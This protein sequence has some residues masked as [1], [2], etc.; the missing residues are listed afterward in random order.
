MEFAERKLWRQVWL[1]ALAAALASPCPAQTTSGRIRGTVQDHSGAV[2]PSVKITTTNTETG[3]QRSTTSN[4][5][6]QYMVY[7][8]PPGIYQLTAGVTGF[9]TERVDGIR[10][11]VADTVL[12]NITLQIGQIEQQVTVSAEATPTLTQTASVESTIV[13]EQIDSLPLNGRDFNQ[14]VLLAAGAVDTNNGGNHDFGGVAVNGNRSFSNDYLLDGTP[15]NDV[16]QGKSAAPVSVDLIRDFKVTSGVAPAEYG[17]AGTQISV[18]TRGGTNQVHGSVFEYYRGNALE[19]RNPFNTGAQQPFRRNQFGGSV[20]GPVRLP[21]YNGVNRTFFYFN[22]EGNR[23]S[24]NVTRVA[25]VPPDDFW[26]GDFSSLLARGIQ[27]RDPLAAGRPVIPNNRLDQ[28][29]GGAFI[30]KTAQA[31][32]PFWGSPTSSGLANNLV[33]YSQEVSNA[34]QFTLRGDQVLPRNQVLALR[35]T[36]SAQGGFTPSILANNTGLSNPVDTNNVSA[37]WTATISARTVSELR[38]GYASFLSI[39]T[40]DDGGLPTVESLKL[41]GFEPGNPGIPPMVRINF[42]GN[43]AFTQLNYGSSESYGM[44]ALTKDSKIYN[45]SEAIS[46]S[47][48][49]HNIKAGFEVRRLPMNSLQQTN[50]RGQLTFRSATSGA[51]TGY[52]FAD[53]LMGL[54]ASTQEV[55]VKQN[56]LFK[57]TETAAYIQDDW[58]V[59]SRLT[60]TLG[61]RHE[62]F[63]NPYEQRNRLAMFDYINGAMVVASDDGKLP[64]DQFLPSVVAKLT[65]AQGNWKFPLIGDKQAG[66]NPRRLVDTQWRHLGPRFGFVNQLDRQGRMVIKG[67]Y[68]IF[69]TRYPIQYLLQTV[70]VNPPFAGLFTYSNSI[71]NGQPLLTLDAPYPGAGGSASVSPNGLQKDFS[72]PSNQ[73]WNLTVERLI[74]W[75]TAVSLGYVGNKGTHLFRSI[76]ANAAYLDQNGVIQR[77]FAS[78]YGTTTINVRLTNGNSIYNAMVLEVRRRARRGLLFQGNWTWAKGLDDV[79]NN[80]NSAM[81]DVQN[82]GRDRADSD[83]VRRHVVKF[84]TTYN[85]PLGRNRFLGGWQLSG[86]WQYTTGMPFT[87]SFTSTGGLSN[88]RPDVVYG[89]QANLPRG[90]R[91]ASRWFNPAAFR[92]VP[93]TDPAS[94]KP[95]Y[96]N[97]G[98]NILRGPGLNVVDVNLSKS[99]RVWKEGRRITF[100]LEAFNALN[101][102]N[103]DF[104]D[105]NISNTNT[106]GSIN[107][108]NRP[109]RQA[110]FA[111]RFDF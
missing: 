10:I 81:L 92:E 17:Q 82:L 91:T 42:T 98:R 19:A 37:T 110:Q 9:Q 23:Q 62:L 90:Q 8:L 94:G 46:H 3:A 72:L 65:D 56:V 28:Y 97:S 52:T 75:D 61:L 79:G 40:Y 83:Y 22:Y 67:G 48:G 108:V 60:L 16:Y 89:V 64:T 2:I 15:N 24:Q 27:L 12:R 43:D 21:R 70:A 85:L 105:S 78:T 7:P 44:A 49:R 111:V 107:R 102:P 104:P 50:A 5:E 100:R 109:M 80:V 101:H 29:A 71:T 86:I 77:R 41:K 51:S 58:R 20:G 74:G 38:F 69:Y 96:G 59:T 68:G 6:G 88:S 84:N 99:V 34:D 39:T 31:L 4:Q 45:V 18:V 54:P 33:R 55:P 35:Y 106:V 25:T 14:L 1:L 63:L 93:A 66:F 87:P 11:D 26:K 36:H 76:N 13:R 53:F 95:R 103:F 47:R 73:Q 32:K 57:Q 30:S